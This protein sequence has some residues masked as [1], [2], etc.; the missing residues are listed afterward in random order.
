MIGGRLRAGITR[1]IGCAAVMAVV[2]SA[3]AFAAKKAWSKSADGTGDGKTAP[4]A[5]VVA[6]DAA[7]AVGARVQAQSDAQIASDKDQTLH[8]MKDEMDRSR[9][10]LQLAGVEKPFYIQFQLLD[11]DIREITTSFGAL[12]ASNT[13]RN[14]F[15]LSG[16]RVGDYHLDSSNFVS[17][18][19]FRGFLGA[20]GQVG[21]DH[22]YSSLR[23]DLWLSV[24]QAYKEALTEMSQKRAFLR[25]LTKPPEIDDFSKAA[26]VVQ[27]EPRVTPDWTARKWEDEARTASAAIRTVPDVR[28][29]RVTYYLIYTTYYLLTSEGTEIRTSRSSAGIEASMD[30][31]ADDGMVVSNYYS[32]YVKV[33]AELPGAADVSASLQA[34]AKDL[35]ALRASPLAP[36]FTGPILLGPNASGA[37]LAQALTPSLSGA[38]PPLSMLPRFD[39]MMQGL[40]GR[41]EWSGHVGTRVLPQGVTLVDDPTQ[42]A[43]EGQALL[44]GYD[45]DDEGVRPQRVSIVEN[46]MLKNLLMMRRPGPEFQA[47]N[48]HARSALL[49]DP[50]ALPSN[51][52]WQTSNGLSADDL[53]KKFLASCKDD[54]H[55]WCV[56]VKVMDNPALSSVRQDDFSDAIGGIA[57]GIGSGMRL[58][59]MMYRVYVSDGHEEL[60]RGGLLNG[61]T[62][63]SL[64]NIQA[65]GKD[66][67]VYNYFQSPA[68][69]FAGTALGAFGS[70]QGG[71]PTSIVAPSLLLEE[72]EVRGFHGE[73]RRLPLVSPPSLQ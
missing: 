52:V 18:E 37:L 6:A 71:M 55:E 70:V 41:S 2:C 63:R 46:G 13:T 56:E 68:Q 65:M 59:L 20:A 9:A 39:E 30:A 14:R 7:A 33:P 73:P 67:T 35:A 57:A 50:K 17:E 32:K 54:G 11:V 22:D 25:S 72:G 29:S 10:R 28:D 51:L 38:R 26:A 45:V 58:P 16:V 61:L 60:V 69:G 24:D 62:L 44:G 15:M 8:A 1:W 49:G 47:S 23:Q 31:V 42:T 53:K 27:V 4:K 34:A 19:G 21:I 12:L 64:R 5:A 40:G 66:S 43:Y 36:D 3:P 48:G